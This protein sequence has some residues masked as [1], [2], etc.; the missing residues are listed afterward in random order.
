MCAD[1][2]TNTYICT[3]VHRHIPTHTG[4]QTHELST[5]Y[6][7]RVVLQTP[8]IRF[9]ASY[10]CLL[11]LL[12]YPF[13][14]SLDSLFDC[15]INLA[16]DKVVSYLAS[17]YFVDLMCFS[18]AVIYN[19]SCSNLEKD[20]F[21]TCSFFRYC[22]SQNL[23]FIRSILIFSRSAKKLRKPLLCIYC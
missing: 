6:K 10:L 17:L 7:C 11:R 14:F 18:F 9:V 1:I 2:Y 19:T 3:Q 4:T 12:S 15:I 16:V 5:A 21:F 13:S 23:L 22:T 20:W 8:A